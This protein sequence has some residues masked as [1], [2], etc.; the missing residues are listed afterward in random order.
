V[1]RVLKAGRY[2]TRTIEQYVP[3]IARLVAWSGG[4]HP[5][6]LA[7]D[8]PARFIESLTIEHRVAPST[9]NQAIAA[10]VFL[11]RDVLHQ[12]YERVALLKPAKVPERLHIVLAPK[13][14]RRMFDALDGTARLVVRL[15]YGAGLRLGEALSLRAKDVDLERREISIYDGK[16]RKSRAT[17]LPRVLVPELASHIERERELW[18]R[19]AKA[20]PREVAVPMPNALDRKYPNAPYEWPWQWIF[21][22]ASTYMDSIDGVRKRAHLHETVIQK[23]VAAARRRIGLSKPVTPHSFRHAY[24]THALRS[25]MD[26][27]TLQQLLGH[28]DLRTTLRYLHACD[29]SEDEVRSPLD[30]LER[31]T[32]PGD[33]PSWTGGL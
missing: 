22:A 17:L 18:T 13:D 29:R 24:A 16:G 6:D 20:A 12:P 10:L 1:L 8:E 5:L 32:A 11:Y 28:S 23:A 25:G 2:S 4:R 7:D 14:V 21:P 15:L 3:W 19:R 31:P 30:L 27:R 26:P 9:Q 33:L